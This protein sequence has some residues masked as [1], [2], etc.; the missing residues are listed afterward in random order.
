MFDLDIEIDPLTN[1]V[2]LGEYYNLCFVYRDRPS[3]ARARFISRIQWGLGRLA[4]EFPWITGQVQHDGYTDQGAKK[5]KIIPFQVTPRFQF[6]DLQNT[7]SEDFKDIKG[8][9]FPMDWI[10]GNHIPIQEPLTGGPSPSPVMELKFTIEPGAS[11]LTISMSSKV[12]DRT[13]LIIMARM[14]VKACIQGKPSPLDLSK[15]EKHAAFFNNDKRERRHD[16]IPVRILPADLQSA[17]SPSFKAKAISW[18]LFSFDREA[19]RGIEGLVS[20]DSPSQYLVDTDQVFTAFVF[21]SLCCARDGRLTSP[22]GWTARCFRTVDA[23][24]ARGARTQADEAEG[25]HFGALQHMTCS[26]F[27]NP[28]TMSIGRIATDLYRASSPFVLSQDVEHFVFNSGNP[29]FSS[30]AIFNPEQDVAVVSWAD[31]ECKNPD[32]ML[33]HGWSPQCIRVPSHLPASKGL[34][35]LMP[36]RAEDEMTVALSLRKTDLESLLTLSD[37]VER[38]KYAAW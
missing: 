3:L 8:E 22:S 19:V 11:I 14:L 12:V 10:N 31:V 24:N 1:R 16:R 32:Y 38:A 37:W 28:S 5:Y 23:R 34:V 9:D 4:K 35:Y 21:R 2:Y 13:G 30:D 6:E 20:G 18:A 17:H 33:T 29:A 27:T 25:I 7:S 26:S 36:R 15:T